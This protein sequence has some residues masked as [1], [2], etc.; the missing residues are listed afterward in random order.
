MQTANQSVLDLY[1]QIICLGAIQPN[2]L[3][4]LSGENK[5][6]NPSDIKL[7]EHIRS[8]IDLG[9]I[10][11]AENNNSRLINIDK[12]IRPTTKINSSKFPIQR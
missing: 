8:K 5:F 1:L 11:I 12:K 3:E 4:F 7:I 2:D 9:E 10:R 6:S